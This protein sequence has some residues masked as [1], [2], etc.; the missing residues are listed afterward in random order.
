MILIETDTYATA[1]G[2][3]SLPGKAVIMNRYALFTDVS[4]NPQHK[5]GVGG[6]LLVPL[7]FLEVELY[8]VEQENVVPRIKIK[9]FVDTSSTK[10]EIQ[11]V[12]WALEETCEALT[13]PGYGS[14]QIYTDSQCVA[15]LLHRRT[16][17][18]HGDF[19]AKRSGHPLAHAPLY[20]A[21]YAAHDQLGFQVIKLPGHSSACSHDTVQRIFSYVD[22]EVRRELKILATTLDS[23][24]QE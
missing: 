14:L 19:I 2:K 1:T 12:L 16:A 6:Y 11:T 8:T 10:L 24:L 23:E 7:S 13:N 22:R 17:L 9:R 5:V 4:V 21:F 3:A 18:T 15:G 20:R